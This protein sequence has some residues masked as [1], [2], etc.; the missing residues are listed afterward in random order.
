MLKEKNVFCSTKQTVHILTCRIFRHI[1]INFHFSCSFP[2]NFCQTRMHSSRILTDSCNCC[3][4]HHYMSVP[5]G[6]PLSLRGQT[7][8]GGRSP[9]SWRQTHP[10]WTDWQTSLK[11]LPSLAVGN[12]RLMHPFRGLAPPFEILNPSL[13]TKYPLFSPQ[14]LYL[15]RWG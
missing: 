10:L 13:I 8:P 15:W 12:Y 14:Y 3:S 6:Y 9:P 4:G 7:P 5:K 2:Q 11:T 1:C